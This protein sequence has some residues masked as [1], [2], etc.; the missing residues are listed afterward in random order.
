M[1]CCIVVNG[2]GCS[3]TCAFLLR[4]V[5]TILLDDS[6]RFQLLSLRQYIYIYIYLFVSNIYFLAAACLGLGIF[7]HITGL[8]SEICLL[9]AM[10]IRIIHTNGFHPV[11]ISLP[12]VLICFNELLITVSFCSLIEG[13]ALND[14]FF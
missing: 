2:R 12:V 9:C 7:G 14:F 1:D 6:L 11:L 4:P 5:A 10:L 13:A 3:S 8:S